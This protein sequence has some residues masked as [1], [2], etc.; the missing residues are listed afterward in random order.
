MSRFAHKCK[1][2]KWYKEE[3]KSPAMTPDFCKKSQF[4]QK[5]LKAQKSQ[6]LSG[7]CVLW[8][9]SVVRCFDFN[10]F[11]EN[12]E[13]WEKSQIS[14]LSQKIATLVGELSSL[15]FQCSVIFCNICNFYKNR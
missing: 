11:S 12:C 10:D 13:F 3:D 6:L 15:A 9:F 7:T 14:Q 1:K 2:R 8:L 4:S 5:S